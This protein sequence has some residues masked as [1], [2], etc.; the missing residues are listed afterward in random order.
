MKLGTLKGKRHEHVPIHDFLQVTRVWG[1]VRDEIF[2]VLHSARQEGNTQF[3]PSLHGLRVH[4]GVYPQI[5]SKL[6]S[7]LHHSEMDKLCGCLALHS[8][9]GIPQ[10]LLLVRFEGDGVVEVRDVR[11]AFYGCFGTDDGLL[12]VTGHDQVF[13]LEDVGHVD[14]RGRTGFLKGL[15]AG[16]KRVPPSSEG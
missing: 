6:D 1:S 12:E 4:Y 8:F 2:S 3:F 14:I 9:L 16:R 7:S 11:T 15:C 10:S 13:D 5:S